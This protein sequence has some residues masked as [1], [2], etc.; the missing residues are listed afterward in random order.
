MNRSLVAPLAAVLASGTA[1]AEASPAASSELSNFQFQ[2]ID[3][4]PADGESSSPS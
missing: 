2:L 3:L 4:D 1:I